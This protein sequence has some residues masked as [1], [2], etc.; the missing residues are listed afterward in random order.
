MKIFDGVAYAM[1]PPPGATDVGIF[2]TIMNFAPLILLVAIFYFLIFRPQQKKQ[3]DVRKMIE[4]LKEGDSVLTQ[5]GI[6]GTISKIKDD[7]LTLQVADGVK[8]KVS[9]SYVVG[10]KSANE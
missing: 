4:N 7:V 10:L 8:I 9:R 5:G 6:Y 3:K 2:E 1:A